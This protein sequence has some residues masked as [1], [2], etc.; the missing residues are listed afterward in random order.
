VYL[1]RIIRPYV[2]GGYTELLS[3]RAKRE[4][5][6]KERVVL[7]RN[8]IPRKEAPFHAY[9][10]NIKSLV[11][12]NDADWDIT[13]AAATA[14]NADAAPYLSAFDVCLLPNSG[15]DD[16]KVRDAARIVFQPLLQNFVNV[17][18]L[19]N[20]KVSDEDKIRLGFVPVT[21]TRVA[22]KTPTTRPASDVEY[23]VGVL[24]IHFHDEYSEHRGKPPKV[25][26]ME[27]IYCFSKL[28]P[29][30]IAQFI[31]SKNATSTPLEIFGEEDERGETM[32]FRLR[33]VGPTTLV[34]PWSE[35]F[36]AIMP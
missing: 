22:A 9:T 15:P 32:W 27:A 24:K 3:P 25:G 16:T 2:C 21:H 11:E 5:E 35:I 14:F 31:H 36:S 1:H 18:L 13:A 12:A 33:W 20:D 19:F 7:F 6:A 26:W 4:A 30:S 34:G 8:P 17:W 28:R 23:G 29:T 10:V